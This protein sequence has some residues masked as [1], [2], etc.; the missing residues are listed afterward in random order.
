[1]TQRELREGARRW[2]NYR[3]R[4]G[5]GLLG[6]GLLF[7]T[8]M[9]GQ[10][11]V[12]GTGMQLF[13]RLHTLMLSL[14]VWAAPGMAA[15]CIVRERREGTLGLLYL[16]PLSAR[17]VVIGKFTAQALRVLTLWLALLPVLTI[18]F[19]TGGVGRGDA[20]SAV[21]IEFCTA[22]V[23]LAAGMAA[24]AL[25]KTRTVA[26]VLAYLLTGTALA[27]FAIVAAAGPNYAGTVPIGEL[28][29]RGFEMATGNVYGP[30]RALYFMGG[31]AV[32]APGGWGVYLSSPNSARLWALTLAGALVASLAT[33]YL[34]LR[35]AVWAIEKSWM[36]KIPSARQEALAARFCTP[37]FG[38]WFQRRMGRRL[39]WNPIAWLQ[40]YS[41]KAR[42]S[43]W[44]LCA[45]YLIAESLAMAWFASVG[46]GSYYELE[47]LASIQQALVFLLA[48]V[49]TFTGV[50]GF[51]NEKRTGALE[52]LLVTPLPVNKIIIG[53]AW[54]LWL[55]F[56]PA[57]LVLLAGQVSVFSLS[58]MSSFHWALGRG[59]WLYLPERSYDAILIAANLF[60]ALPIFAT[61]A[62]LRL[63][64]LIGAAALTWLGAFLVW[65]TAMTMTEFF[66]AREVNGVGW[67]ALE[68]SNAGYI[69]LTFY[70]LRHSLS[71]RIYAF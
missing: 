5:A 33:L 52:L 32:F 1:M 68:A 6:A 56:L 63:K 11:D 24:S 18:P 71:R 20:F 25:A 8:V 51:L 62:A 27:G 35:L 34:S 69:A 12:S 22:T 57:A 2:A 23:C 64:N 4:V 15:D 65:F 59:R 55:Q 49:L 50:S 38:G 66:Y 45:V 39:D 36:D 10:L 7:L 31:R 26:F 54:G 17:G 42:A 48:A 9:G 41:W 13:R 53:R 37:L 14:I 19:L 29:A 21:T 70:L 60:I 61:Y 3:L 44:G 43:K 40:Q 58:G 30:R 46:G 28:L 16:T 47:R 67:F